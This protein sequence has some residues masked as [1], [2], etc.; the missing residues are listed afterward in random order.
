MRE[1][2]SSKHAGGLSLHMVPVMSWHCGKIRYHVTIA[3]F[4]AIVWNASNDIEFR[5]P[6]WTAY[7][8]LVCLVHYRR[9][10]TYDLLVAALV[11][12]AQLQGLRPLGWFYL[13]LG[14]RER[15][16]DII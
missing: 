13:K 16:V 1:D 11:T 3:D 2:T 14:G 7:I 8:L 6:Q 5:C 15:H 4:L 10:L 9:L 12:I